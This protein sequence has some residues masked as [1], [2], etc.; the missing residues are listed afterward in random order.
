MLDSVLNGLIGLIYEAAVDPHL[1]PAM[2]AAVQ[3]RFQ[4]DSASLVIRRAGGDDTLFGVSAA[5]LLGTAAPSAYSQ[6]SPQAWAND[7]D[8]GHQTLLL[9]FGNAATSATMRLV[10]RHGWQPLGDAERRALELIRPHLSR[11]L[12]ISALIDATTTTNDALVGALNATPRGIVLVDRA[13]RI[14]HANQSA[15]DMLQRGDAIKEVAGRL[16]LVTSVESEQMAEA[17][18]SVES[19][20]LRVSVPA[21]RPDGSSFVV[22]VVPLQRR[23]GRTGPASGAVAAI[24]LG[25]V[26][27]RQQPISHAVGALYGLTQAESRVF[28]YVA[29][30]RSN[31]E[32][33]I[34]L[35]IATSTIRTHLLRIFDKVGRHRRLDLIRLAMELRV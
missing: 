16:D 10:N 2:L 14:V 18:A 7:P 35:G 27:L 26:R 12:E 23:I 4:C 1:W 31:R 8:G 13:L 21:S 24:L 32:I 34:E 28:E 11:A 15:A 19:K 6:G 5:A 30:G 20:V 17:V 29:A 22:H 3:Q 33:A 25:D 9:T